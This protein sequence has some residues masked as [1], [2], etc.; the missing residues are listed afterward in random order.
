MQG[1]LKDAAA[2][3]SLRFGGI[4]TFVI[5][6]QIAV[7]VMFLASV[8]ALASNLVTES[9]ATQA[10]TFS[11]KE[12]L[13]FSL[14]TERNTPPAQMRALYDELD[15]RLAADPGISQVTYADTY[16][17]RGFE[18]IL[19]VEGQPLRS[20]GD[21][22]LWVRTS[23]VSANYFDAL[24]VPL[25]AGRGFRPADLGQPVAIVDETFVR[26]VLGGTD[27]LGARVRRA[28]RATAPAGPWIQII[29]VVRDLSLAKPNKTSEDAILFRPVAPER[30]SMLRILVRTKGD[31]AQA[32]PAVRRAT[33]D[34][35]PTL[36]IHDLMALERI[37]DTDIAT[38]RFFVTAVSVVAV[39]A[40]VLAT[41]G[42][43]ALMSFTL[44]R[45]TREIG[46]RAALGA[47]PR[48]IVSALFTRTF[49]LVGIGVLIGSLPGGVLLS[50]GLAETA[51]A[52]L[53]ATLTG[54]AVSALF[55][56]MVAMLTGV[57]PARRA[58]RIQPT[59]ALRIDG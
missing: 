49:V 21:R 54:T 7:T 18:F 47:A 38:G 19:D 6:A 40:L 35:D 12:V 36:R 39:V 4:W 16:P 1:R 58:L 25:L 46:I 52:S 32:A 55:V 22:P 45:R 3:G 24:G 30:A 9:H 28:Q 50:F 15:G 27:P 31:A 20:G 2:G 57:V 29:G 8:L 5:V 13:T 14:V 53:W 43:Y 11:P 42:I 17:G 23:S 56:V 59:D 51:G 26:Q 10:F 34:T 33:A 41:A 44:A 48:R 37:E